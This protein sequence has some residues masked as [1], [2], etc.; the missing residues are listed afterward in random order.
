[1][2]WN[3]YSNAPAVGTALC[4]LEDVGPGQIHEVQFGAGR[5]AFRVF[6]TRAGGQLRA[7]V[8]RCPH[9]QVPMNR[10]DGG[11]LLVN[12]VLWCAQ[13]SAQF[14]LDDGYCIDGPCMGANLESVPL[15]Q[16]GGYLCIAAS[17]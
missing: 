8:N 7:Y 9:F 5:E 4:R 6:V 17:E 1:M 16:R 10:R 12:E 13:H 11:F 3:D 2:A 14:R 15:E